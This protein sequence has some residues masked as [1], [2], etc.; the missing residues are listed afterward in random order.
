MNV[1]LAL[2]ASRQTSQVCKTL[3]Y[4]AEEWC[5]TWTTCASVCKA[6]GDFSPLKLSQ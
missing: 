1:E 4:G 5:T 6:T 2:S 3:M